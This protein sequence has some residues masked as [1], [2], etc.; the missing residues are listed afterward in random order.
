MTVIT[1]ELRLR[2]TGNVDMV[3]LTNEV[4]QAVQQSGLKEGL[5]TVFVPGSTAAVTTMEFEPGLQRDIKEF[6]EALLP[7]SRDWHH[8]ETWHDYNGHSHMR[9]TLLGP[10][11]SIPFAEGEPLLGTWQ[12][13]VVLDFDVR[14]R[15][16]RVILQVLG[17]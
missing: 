10:S 1:R 15:D 6:L 13:V 7:S 4:R 3:D 11:L 12:Q 9:A 8:N 14:Q 17:E 16:R 2:S 5:V